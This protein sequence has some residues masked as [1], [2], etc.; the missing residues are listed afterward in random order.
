V[1]DDSV[2][3]VE[4]KPRSVFRPAPE[5]SFAKEIGFLI[6][7][8]DWRPAPRDAASRRRRLQSARLVVLIVLSA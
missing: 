8:R 4:K 1:R 7:Q 2:L 6:R 5:L 3:R